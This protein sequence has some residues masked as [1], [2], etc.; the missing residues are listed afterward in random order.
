M[1]AERLLA[2]YDRVAEA[3]DAI[4]RLRRFVLDLAV[5]GK[6][7]E[8][9]AADEPASEL[10]KRIA[11][12]KA[13]LVKTK[14][15]RKPRHF[16]NG[17]DLAPPFE[18]PASWC[19]CR[20]DTV[21]AIIGGG[22]PSATDPTNFAEPGEGIP[23]LTPADLG[24]CSDL[25][26]ERG[27]RDL[28]EKGVQSSSATM[29]PVGTVLFTSR[30]PIGYVAIAAN[31][32]ATNQGFKS[33]VPYVADCSRF[34]ALVMQTFAPEIDANAP[35]TTFKEVSGKIVA[36]V[37]F[38]LPPLAEQHRIV[39]KVDELM[40][41]CDRL[42]ATRTAREDTRDRLTKASLTRL[43][44][45]DT[46][47][48]TFHSYA[49]FAVDTLPALTTRGD[50]VKHLRQ[51][52]LN[53][54][55]RGKLVEQDP[56][57]EPAEWLIE[58]AGSIMQSIV[59]NGEAS[60]M[61]AIAPIEQGKQLFDLPAGWS[62]VRF[63]QL[64]KLI[65]KGSSPKWQGIEYVAKDDGVLF[66]TSENVGIYDLQKLDQLKF[67]EHRFNEIEPRSILQKGDL[68]LNLVGA[69]IGR[70][71][72]FDLDHVA[73]INQ[74]V[75]LI[76]PIL[77]GEFF[78]NRYV[79][80][81]LNSPTGVGEMLGSRVISAQPNISLTDTRNFLIPLPPLAEQHRIVAKVDELMALCDRLEAGLAAAEDTRSHL[82][83]AVLAEA[84]TAKAAKLAAS[85]QV[86]TSAV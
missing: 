16:A 46:D 2:F 22:T 62:C 30:A 60:K 19:W 29:M 48:V 85:E 78:V 77:H 73:N 18:V 14:E 44:A 20:L 45:P 28:S 41:L 3:P 6:L 64:A 70:A 39:A 66:I 47:A 12:E 69:S 15:I 63:G 58:R 32:I 4:A 84:L 52:I 35:G 79:L 7:L 37:P 51:T 50:Q 82:L 42:E 5:R 83:D 40:A 55:V 75:A 38:P 26:I 72:E 61:K 57:D 9:D 81:Y 80:H 65:T 71:A 1:N 54:A 33:I 49:R 68:L 21:G 34:I 74:A 59:R 86:V 23:W 56:A 25:Y 53:L 76:R 31:L 8:Q 10:L 27:S 11:A 13:R 36:G 67:V 43:S 17:G 24:G